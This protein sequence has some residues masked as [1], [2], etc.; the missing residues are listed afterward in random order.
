MPA[1][2]WILVVASLAIPVT[3]VTVATT[4][5]REPQNTPAAPTTADPAYAD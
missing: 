4:F 1:W 5:I 2:E 3:A